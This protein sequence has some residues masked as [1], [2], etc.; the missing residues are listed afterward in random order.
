MAP[1]NIDVSVLLIFFVRPETFKK[2]FEQV[3][4]ARPARL[5][6][7]QD[8]PRKGN[9]TDLE[10]I[11]KCREI[12]ENIDWECEVYKFYQEKNFGVDPSGYI[13]NKW[14]FSLT[15]KCIVLEDDD[16]ASVCFFNFCKKMLDK[17]E[18]D[19]RIMLITGIN[20]EEIT[21]DINSDYFFSAT[22]Y[23]NGWAS[24]GR[25]VNNWDP[26]YQCLKD[27]NSKKKIKKFI[28]DHGLLKKMPW[29][30]KRHLDSGIEHWETILI[31]NQYLHEGLTIVP[32]KNMINNIGLTNDSAHYAN[33][34]DKLPKGA[35]KI[36][37]MNRY[38]IDT[39]NLHEPKEVKDFRPYKTRTYRINAW[40]HPGIKI[41]RKVEEF[42]YKII[43]K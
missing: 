30:F 18:K 36:F 27:K 38:E 22:T 2:T 31:S 25:V 41:Y 16:V 39:D 4:K 11:K 19:E 8:G 42:V 37:T 17:Y 1:A 9:L 33:S 10:N 3:R 12:A 23:T 7:Y 26:T 6:L 24:W 29:V 32:K 15:E 13:A 14:A 20:E 5:F 40:G 34:I 43:Y 35:R 28:S 21:E